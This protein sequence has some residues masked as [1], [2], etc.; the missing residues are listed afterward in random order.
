MAALGCVG[1]FHDPHTHL[2]GGD[3]QL[4]DFISG[5]SAALLKHLV[6]LFTLLMVFYRKT[7][8]FATG[9]FAFALQK[10]AL[11]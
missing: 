6:W 10:A 5:H 9:L 4:L 2:A 8:K 7:A 11:R 1:G 3:G